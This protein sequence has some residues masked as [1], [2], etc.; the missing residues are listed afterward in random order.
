MTVEEYQNALSGLTP[1]QFGA[2]CGRWGGT[3]ETA[4]A[5]V[6]EFAYAKDPVQWEQIIVF[7]LRA[8]GVSDLK[9]E[10]EKLTERAERTAAAA[11][12]SATAAERSA[13]AAARIEPRSLVVAAHCSAGHYRHARCRTVL[14]SRIDVRFSRSPFRS[15]CGHEA[16]HT[17]RSHGSHR[18][19]HDRGHQSVTLA[20][21]RLR[22]TL[23]AQRFG[24]SR[25]AQGTTGFYGL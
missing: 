20:R 7:H 15:L 17:L 2:F 10:G 16:G 11:V 5:C 23:P 6:Q 19:G 8:L 24:A 14:S 18:G 12:A 4:D 1:E 13:K 3:K 21:S 25:R 9:T 22:Y